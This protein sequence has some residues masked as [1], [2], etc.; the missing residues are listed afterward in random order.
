[1]SWAESWIVKEL[2]EIK[3]AGLWRSFR[4]VQGAQEARVK[5]NGREVVNLCSNNYLGLANHPRLHEAAQK[6]VKK[7]GC[8]GGA[9]RLICGNN[10]LNDELEERLARFKREERA[11]VFS[12]GYQANMGI[13]P[14]LTGRDGIIFSD[15]LNHASIIDGVRLSRS[16]ARIYPHCDPA[17][18]RK[19]VEEAGGYDR[20]LIVTES[21]FSMDGDIAP[22]AEIAQVAEEKGLM[23]MVD[24]AHATG[25]LGENGRGAV[26]EQGLAGELTAVMGTLGK[27]LGSFGA[28]IC[29]SNELIDL[30]INRSRTFIFTTSLP[31][32]VLATAI[33]A[34]KLLETNDT[35]RRLLWANTKY[36]SKELVQLGFDVRVSESPIIPL[37]IGENDLTMEFCRRLLERDILI[38]GIRPPTVPKGSARLRITLMATHSREDLEKALEALKDIGR[39]LHII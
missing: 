39:E 24:E 31:P 26:N 3:D 10:V 12:T 1:M 20:G 8:G 21:V 13:I 22:L 34:I 5:I 38:Q 16:K 4:S 36:F 15:R 37:M 28:Y 11:L 18:L 19:E 6:A 17:G 27:A 7:F 29:G 35:L 30:L 23:M 32:A 9:S 33:E 14:V 2:A 25:V